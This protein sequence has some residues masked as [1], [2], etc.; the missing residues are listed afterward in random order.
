MNKIVMAITGASG[1]PYALT[2]VQEL[3][4]L[5][6]E[7]HLV[8]SSAAYKVL[9]LESPGYEATLSLVENIYRQDDLGAPMASGSFQ[10]GGMVVC[11]CSMASLA[12]IAQGLGSNLIHRAADVTLKENRRLVLVPRET[13]L[14]RVHLQNMLAARDAG[15]VILPPCPGFYNKPQE[16]QDLIRHIAARIMDSLGIENSVSRRWEGG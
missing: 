9:Q 13:P 16:M 14:N 5:D 4:S 2:L 3:I 10:H 12:A 11:P 6:I 8:V 7:L 15:A 1:M